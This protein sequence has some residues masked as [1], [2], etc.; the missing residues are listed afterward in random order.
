MRTAAGL[1]QESSNKYIYL[2][3]YLLYR[4]SLIFI[5]GF[6]IGD[7]GGAEEH[8]QT[9][10]PTHTG[11]NIFFGTYLPEVPKQSSTGTEW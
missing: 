10:T 9:H 1:L 6:V 7:H 8:T 3:I 4:N 11:E 5:F 2:F